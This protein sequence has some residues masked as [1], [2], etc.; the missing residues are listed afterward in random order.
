MKKLLL[1]GALVC[2]M[3]ADVLADQATSSQTPIA[4]TSS[5]ND[6]DYYYDQLMPYIGPFSYGFMIGA[7]TGCFETELVN[8]VVSYALKGWSDLFVIATE[9]GLIGGAGYLACKDQN[10]DETVFAKPASLIGVLAGFIAWYN[11][12]G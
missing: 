9:L 8:P 12:H 1:V 4:A 5:S 3:Y 11:I 6:L 10:S 7:A 2:G